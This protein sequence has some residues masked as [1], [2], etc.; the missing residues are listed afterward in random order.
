M[1]TACLL[2]LHP[3]SQRYPQQPC[4]RGAGVAV[5][6]HQEGAAQITAEESQPTRA[7]SALTGRPRDESRPR[8]K[9]SHSTA[10]RRAASQN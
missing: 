1:A 7:G 3:R 10:N 8:G 6:E 4:A 2:P 9:S 5:R